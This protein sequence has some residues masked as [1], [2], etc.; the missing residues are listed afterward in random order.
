VI[1]TEL[2]S[3]GHQKLFDARTSRR[4][5]HVPMSEAQ[6]LRA[7]RVVSVRSAAAML[8]TFNDVDHSGLDEVLSQYGQLFL[9]STG[10]ELTSVSFVVKA[11]V[12]ALREFQTMNA[13]VEKNELILRAYNDID[14]LVE[15]EVGSRAT[16]LRNSELMTFAQIEARAADSG[17]DRCPERQAGEG[18]A[19]TFGVEIQRIPNSM[20]SI[21]PLKSRQSAVLAIGQ[22]ILRPVIINGKV[23]IRPMMSAALT[24]DHRVVDG[25]ESVRFLVTV[26][27]LLERPKLLMS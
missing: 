20:I 10:V 18:D 11:V 13:Y 12:V 26:K 17:N 4:S 21:P 3:A 15:N 9:Q 19:G 27:D 14:L 1:S 5:S 25:R 2:E 24:Y 16:L 6:R 8:T 7:Q 22:T 23:F